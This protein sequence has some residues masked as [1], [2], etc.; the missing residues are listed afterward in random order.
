MKRWI[1]GGLAA[2]MLFSS[3]FSVPMEAYAE[4][5]TEQRVSYSDETNRQ[6]TSAEQEADQLA[7]TESIKASTVENEAGA[8]T[9]SPIPV[10]EVTPSPTPSPSEE[11]TGD[12]QATPAP[13]PDA[14]EEVTAATPGPTPTPEPKDWSGEK[15]S[16]L[17]SL[18]GLQNQESGDGS[19][20]LE[21]SFPQMEQSD[22]VRPGD[23]AVFALPVNLMEIEDSETPVDI[24]AFVLKDEEVVAT[25][26]DAV[27]EAFAPADGAPQKRLDAPVYPGYGGGTGSAVFVG[28][29]GYGFKQEEKE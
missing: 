22:S 13:S 27:A 12:M 1:T 29:G 15:D 24:F 26:E 7:D 9:P 16:F 19:L 28:L 10:A 8:A 3:L 23:G 17:I 5:P 20:L 6:P 21:I 14:G 11:E 2:A 18:A 25:E 4:G